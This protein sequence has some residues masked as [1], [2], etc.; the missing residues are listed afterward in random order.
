MKSISREPIAKCAGCPALNA[1]K[2]TFGRFYDARSGGGEG[3]DAPFTAEQA[4][5]I[6]AAVAQGRADDEARLIQSE[7]DA[8]KAEQESAFAPRVWIV[9]HLRQRHETTAK[10]EKGAIN[11]VRYLLYR[12]RPL[13][14]CAPF[15]AY[16]KPTG[17]KDPIP[18]TSAMQRL[19][20]LTS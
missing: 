12:N 16:P 18:M 20:R 19:A 2:H 7:L 15:R 6:E 5:R 17:G 11:N 8:A 13:A 3:C 9:E 10:T 14:S 1:C 4:R